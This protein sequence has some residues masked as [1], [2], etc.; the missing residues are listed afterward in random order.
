MLIVVSK[1]SR[2][3]QISWCDS[4]DSKAMY[5]VLCANIESDNP[6]EMGIIVMT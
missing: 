6:I 3:T 5:V 1:D 4:D 2:L